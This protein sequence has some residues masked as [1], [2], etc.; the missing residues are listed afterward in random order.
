MLAAQEQSGLMY[1]ITHCG[2]PASWAS[3]EPDPDVSSMC[4]V[5]RVTKLG[6]RPHEKAPSPPPRP[7]G[8]FG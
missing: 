8:R 4:Q 5:D 3:P 2:A 7:F 1:K 6:T